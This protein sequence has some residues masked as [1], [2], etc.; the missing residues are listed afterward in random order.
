MTAARATKRCKSAAAPAADE[1][2]L[3]LHASIETIGQEAKYLEERADKIE[4]GS[5]ELIHR[6][7]KKV[8]ELQTTVATHSRIKYK[9]SWTPYKRSVMLING[10]GIFREHSLLIPTAA[11]VMYI[12]TRVLL[13]QEQLRR[14]VS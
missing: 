12:L 10:K 14:L 4:S 1:S 6:L 5:N 11:T 7:N 13:G 8:S 2:I 3:Q 9:R